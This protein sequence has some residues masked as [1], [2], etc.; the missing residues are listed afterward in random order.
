MEQKTDYLIIGSG[1][2]GYY[3][4]TELLKSNANITMITADHD[5]PYNRPP[6]SKEYLRGEKKEKPYFKPP[7][8]YFSL[9][10]V[11]IM[12]NTKVESININ[13]KEAMLLNGDIIEFNKALIATGGSPRRLGVSGENLRGVYYLR[14]LRDADSIKEA[15]S[16]SKNPV[17]IGGGFIG[18]EAAASMATLGLKPTIIE[19]M[20]RIWTTFIGEEVSRHLQTYFESKGVKILT[21][22][23]VKE[24]VGDDKVNAVIT[25]GGK[26]IDADLVIVAVGIKPNVEIALNSGIDVNNGIIA[27]E[28]LMTSAKDIYTAGDVANIYDPNLNK[29]RRIEHWNN[30]WYCGKLAARNMMGS[31]EKYN[32]LS[33]VWSDIFDIHIEAGGE[34][35]DYD[36]YVLKGNMSTNKFLIVYSKKGIIN[37][38]VA[39]NWDIKELD[40]LNDMIVK[41]MSISELP[42]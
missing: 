28:Y 9:K 5:Y 41:K 26:R 29:R 22:E 24:I 13:K 19:V 31:N 35:I 23:K 39:F 21:N 34:T 7:E 30:A 12:L 10:N 15:M 4:L 16:V 18:I 3:A 42:K 37:G 25:E 32:F 38:Y 6:L 2:A 40:K 36:N 33:T 20:P 27:N 8:Y 11:K 17:I 14:S 1:I